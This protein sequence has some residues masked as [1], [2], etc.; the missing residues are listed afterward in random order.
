MLRQDREFI[1]PCQEIR[2]TLH[3]LAQP[4]A[5]VAGLV[6]LL[7]LQ[8]NESDAR[9]YDVQMIS[10][11]LEKVL[12]IIGHIRRIARE[13]TETGSSELEQPLPPLPTR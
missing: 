8:M 5:A 7:L 12:E 1:N 9:F 10:Q 2:Q 6:D 4:L 11:Q 13:A 3:E